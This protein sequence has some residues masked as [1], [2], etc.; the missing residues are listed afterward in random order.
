MFGERVP[1]LSGAVATGI[2]VVNGRQ[3]FVEQTQLARQT[4]TQHARLL[5]RDPIARQV[6]A[7]ARRGAKV[8]PLAVNERLLRRVLLRQDRPVE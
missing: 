2:D 8:D 6:A 7:R 1:L 4:Y 3:V 5:P